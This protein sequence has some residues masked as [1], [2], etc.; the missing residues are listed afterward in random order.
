[1]QQILIA[2]TPENPVPEAVWYN[3]TPQT[4]TLNNIKR[5]FELDP[6]NN[7]F[8]ILTVTLTF[9]YKEDDCYFDSSAFVHPDPLCYAIEGIFSQRDMSVIT[10]MFSN[11]GSILCPKKNHTDLMYEIKI[12]K[13]KHLFEGHLVD[14]EINRIRFSQNPPQKPHVTYTRDSWMKEYD[15]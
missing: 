8:G 2:P 5:I 12:L 11:L 4:P 14:Y 7:V 1:M 13:N 9:F 6:Y 15:F 3:L 10:M